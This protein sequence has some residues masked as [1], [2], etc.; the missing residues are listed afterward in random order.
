MFFWPDI[1]HVIR[2]PTEESLPTVDEV[3]GILRDV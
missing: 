3:Q 1:F 2:L